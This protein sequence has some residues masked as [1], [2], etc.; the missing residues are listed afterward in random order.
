MES[1]NSLRRI[2][3]RYNVSSTGKSPVSISQNEHDSE[4]ETEIL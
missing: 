4:N 3:R 1:Q 2:T